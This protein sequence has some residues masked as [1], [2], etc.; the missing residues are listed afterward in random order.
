MSFF[1]Y[2]HTCPNGKKYIG[3]TSRIPEDRWDNGNGY[4]KHPHFYLAIQKYGWDNIEHEYFEVD[5]KE[6]MCYWEKI[7]IYYYKTFDRD[8]GYNK[9]SGG[10]SGFKY[11]KEHNQKI[12]E[13]NKL[14]KGVFKHSEETKEKM[15][16][17]RKGRKTGPLSEEHKKKISQTLTGK[18]LTE[19]QKKKISE[20]NKGKK[21]S[22]ESRKKYSE[23]KKLYWENKKKTK[24]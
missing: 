10:L 24:I 18:P 4:N 23:A 12:G 13:A 2:I 20:G 11:H 3:A 7:L 6:L 19:E 16:K 15:S 5:S 21:R 9:T 1:V 22:E 17:T 8:F 14:R